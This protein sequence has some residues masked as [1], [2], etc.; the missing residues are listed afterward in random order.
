[1]DIGTDTDATS[2]P[3]RTLSGAKALHGAEAGNGARPRL[4]MMGAILDAIRPRGAALRI[5]EAAD[6]GDGLD[7]ISTPDEIV[8]VGDLGRNGA[9]GRFEEKAFDCAVC[10][11][12][13]HRLDATERH[14][15]L[16]RLR[17]AARGVVLVEAPRATN[18]HNPLEEVIELFHESGD[19]VLVLS[20]EHLPALLTLRELGLGGDSNGRSTGPNMETIAQHLFGPSSASSRAVL[21][22]IIDPDAGIDLSALQWCC[23]AS[24][25]AGRDPAGLAVLPLSLEVRRLSDRLD[26]ERVRGNRAEAEAGDLRR[27]VAELARIA[28]EDRSARESADQLVEIVAA[29][30]GYRIGLALCRARAVVR[31]RAGSAWRFVTTPWRAAAARLR[32]GPPSAADQ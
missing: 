12:M 4:S 1:M 16:A 2:S 3:A 21:V 5:L 28:S 23:S 20:D 29:A 10:T 13:V 32:S 8:R 14:A 26:A 19:S 22:S 6:D 31:R 24:S 17:R 11:D 27:K 7:A 30:R 15:L 25:A 18:G 9:A